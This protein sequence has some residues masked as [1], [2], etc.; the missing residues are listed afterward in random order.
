MLIQP[1]QNYP[2][3]KQNFGAKLIAQEQVLNVIKQEIMDSYEKCVPEARIRFYDSATIP[4]D[5]QKIWEGLVKAFEE[6]TEK[7][8]G[9][10]E[11]IIPKD[12]TYTAGIKYTSGEETFITPSMIEIFNGRFLRP[13]KQFD[14]GKPY[15]TAIH[16]ICANIAATVAKI[17]GDDAKKNPFCALCNV[18]EKR[19]LS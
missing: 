10:V 18:L 11:L 15:T 6:T 16:D 7:I 9:V 13:D 12:K 1:N 8:P 2:I 19:F 17:H 4:P 3:Q 5:P 14:K